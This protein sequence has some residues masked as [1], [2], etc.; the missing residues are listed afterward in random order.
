MFGGEARLGLE[1][2]ASVLEIE[3]RSVAGWGI[4]PKRAGGIH[5]LGWA[6]N[7]KKHQRVSRFRCFVKFYYDLE[8]KE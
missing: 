2:R 3:K 8:I 7:R 5:H 6:V 4:S 1:T